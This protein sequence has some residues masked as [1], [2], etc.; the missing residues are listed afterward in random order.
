MELL[1]W[2]D[3]RGSDSGSGSG[4]GVG[5]DSDSGT[6]ASHGALDHSAYQPSVAD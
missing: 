2:F 4:S 1:S 3:R 6:P 5:S